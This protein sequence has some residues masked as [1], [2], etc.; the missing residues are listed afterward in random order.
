MIQETV[1]LITLAL[2]ACITGVFI[3]VAINSSKPVDDYE[4]VQQ[5][6]Y[7]L[8]TKFFWGLVVAGV[9]IY[10]A[11]TQ[12]LP[13]A[14]T[15]GTLPAT[16]VEIDVVGKQWFWELS[17]QEARVGETVIFNVSSADVNHGLGIYDSELRLLAQT[18]AMPGYQNRLKF[19]FEEPGEYRLMCLE[20][21]GLAHHVM[22]TP[23]RVTS[24][25]EENEYVQ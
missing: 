23:F 5:R 16:A 1:W 4:A 7:S 18:Q 6:A 17:Q 21:C 11:T 15:R 9:I 14:A 10:F 20:Y 22:I 8:R 12:I 13:Y 3:Y 24:V 25:T 19:T 2:M